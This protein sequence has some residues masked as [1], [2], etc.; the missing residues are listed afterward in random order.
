MVNGYDYT[1]PN[2]KKNNI[3]D[4]YNK[5]KELNKLFKISWGLQEAGVYVAAL[6]LRIFDF[7]EEGKADITSIVKSSEYNATGLKVLLD[8]L[9]GLEILTCDDKYYYVS[10]EFSAYLR[11]DSEHYIGGIWKVHKD[12][13]FPVWSKLGESIVSGNPANKLFGNEMNKV[14]EVVVPYLNSISRPV[15]EEIRRLLHLDNIT[16]PFNILDVGCGSGIYGQLIAVH[17]ANANVVGI[18]R[19]NVLSIAEEQARRMNV[20]RQIQY[21]SGDIFEVDYGIEQYDF[22]ILSHILHGFSEIENKKLLE[23]CYLALKKGGKL[24]INEFIVEDRNSRNIFPLL[25]GV[26][27]FLVGTGHAYTIDEY[28]NLLNG[29]KFL[30]VSLQHITGPSNLIFAEKGEFQ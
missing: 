3:Q 8:A 5:N 28:S 16:T 10:N 12:L 9:V 18:D 13:N 17:N 24:I 22:L 25:F 23:K 7:F 4:Y 20:D 30:N 2:N 1:I 11:T 15:V 21:V 19:K 6:E 27:A 14:W 29:S 26:E